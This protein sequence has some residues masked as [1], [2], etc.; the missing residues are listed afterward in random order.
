ML[1]N[2]WI[3]EYAFHLYNHF[4][5]HV[6]MCFHFHSFYTRNKR[7]QINFSVVS[8]TIWNQSGF[9]TSLCS[10]QVTSE[11]DEEATCFAS[12]RFISLWSGVDYKRVKSLLVCQGNLLGSSGWVERGY[13]NAVGLIITRARF[14]LPDIFIWEK[15]CKLFVI[16][17]SSSNY[18]PPICKTK[19][20]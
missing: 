5:T 8:N 14:L 15:A 18:S 7:F 2:R 10:S 6:Q 17:D 13:V 1:L 16:L 11:V 3:I 20:F 4:K 12:S 19:S 9:K